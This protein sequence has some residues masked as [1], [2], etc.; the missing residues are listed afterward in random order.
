MLMMVSLSLGMMFMGKRK[1]QAKLPSKIE[2][3][4]DGWEYFERA[5]DA[6]VKSGPKH[7]VMQKPRK[8]KS[9]QPVKTK[10]KNNRK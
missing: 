9:T 1:T 3:R 5:I 6:A 7:R 8:S 4:S 10:A 2:L